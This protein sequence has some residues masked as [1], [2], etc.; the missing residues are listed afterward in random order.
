MNLGVVGELKQTV[1]RGF[2]LPD[3]TAA[4]TLDIASL[5]KHNRGISY[6]PLPRFPKVSQDIS[7]KVPRA[8]NFSDLFKLVDDTVRAA[9]VSSGY[10]LV[11]P[12]A[13]YQ[14][15]DDDTKTITF[16]IEVASETGTLTD[17]Q[18]GSVLDAVAERATNEL[19][20][21]RV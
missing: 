18:V 13:I 14:P 11:E 5:L 8:T 19:R 9:D 2:K 12:Q 20:A 6:K 1:R 7:L 21:Q 16:H 10:A 15:E 17:K 4:A 3:Y